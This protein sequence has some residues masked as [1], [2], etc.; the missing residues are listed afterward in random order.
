MQDHTSNLPSLEIQNISAEFS[1]ALKQ[2]PLELADVLQRKRSEVAHRTGF[3]L[4]FEE[5]ESRSCRIGLV[6]GSRFLTIGIGCFVNKALVLTCSEVLDTI[7]DVATFRDGSPA[8]WTKVGM[9]KYEEKKRYDSG[10]VLLTVG[11]IDTSYVEG[12]AAT[13]D[14]SSMLEAWRPRETLVKMERTVLPGELVGFVN[15]PDNSQEL[16]LALSFQFDSAAVAFRVKPSANTIADF[17]LTPV[18]SRIKYRGAPVFN[19]A[20]FLVGVLK[21]TIH[22]VDENGF[23]PIITTLLEIKGF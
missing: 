3:P 1:L 6:G 21:D 18:Q 5:F 13:N 23:R 16:R 2:A 15:G 17:S 8:I 14:V 20:G 12:V 10:L 7:K 19:E 22:F 9:A 4:A 11:Q